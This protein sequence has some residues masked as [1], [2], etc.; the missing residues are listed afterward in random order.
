[1]ISITPGERTTCTHWEGGWVDLRTSL[2]TEAT[3]ESFA[4][5]AQE[6]AS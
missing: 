3:K 6:G 2:D 4:P 1:M 5:A